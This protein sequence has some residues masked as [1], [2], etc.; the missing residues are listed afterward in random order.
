[1]K[2]ADVVNVCILYSPEVV[3]VPPVASTIGTYAVSEKVLGISWYS[4]SIAVSVKV[5]TDV[6]PMSVVMFPLNP[7]EDVNVVPGGT[8]DPLAMAYVTFE[9]EVALNV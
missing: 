7:P 4:L 6:F 3:T 2:F 5:Y 8:A 1:M 9:S